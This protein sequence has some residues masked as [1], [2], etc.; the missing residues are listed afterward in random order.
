MAQPVQTERIMG[1]LRAL[2][3]R[4]HIIFILAR[5]HRFCDKA[6]LHRTCRIQ[7]HSYDAKGNINMR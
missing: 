7:T 5:I 2:Y 1:G 3:L 6:V 4:H